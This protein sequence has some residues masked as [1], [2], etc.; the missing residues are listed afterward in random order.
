MSNALNWIRH[1]FCLVE[2]QAEQ[3]FYGRNGQ[4]PWL[5]Y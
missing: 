3:K 5:S 4:A 2:E 1:F